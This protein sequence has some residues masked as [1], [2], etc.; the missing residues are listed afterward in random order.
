MRAAR[1]LSNGIFFD[2]LKEKCTLLIGQAVWRRPLNCQCKVISTRSGVVFSVSFSWISIQ[3]LE[4]EHQNQYQKA[5]YYYFSSLHFCFQWK[6]WVKLNS[7][8]S[9]SLLFCKAQKCW[10]PLNAPLNPL[11]TDPYKCQINNG[12]TLTTFLSYFNLLLI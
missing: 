6:N 5:N 3:N 9:L 12:K 8:L 1:D 4:R 2:W 10:P 11:L 7:P